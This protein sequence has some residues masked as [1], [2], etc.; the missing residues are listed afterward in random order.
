[1]SDLVVVIDGNDKFIRLEDARGAAMKHRI[2]RVEEMAAAAGQLTLIAVDPR[3]LSQWKKEHG[4]NA[5]EVLLKDFYENERPAGLIIYLQESTARIGDAVIHTVRKVKPFI[6]VI[7]VQETEINSR[8]HDG[9]KH[10]LKSA[11]DPEHVLLEPKTPHGLFPKAE[12]IVRAIKRL[13]SNCVTCDAPYARFACAHCE[14]V[15]YCNEDCQANDW[16][17]HAENCRPQ[18]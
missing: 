1:M 17:K 10:A 6:V 14:S 8:T 2:K 7:L 12:E 15:S 3:D 4:L 18:T 13:A 9:M 11:M 5:R 16:S